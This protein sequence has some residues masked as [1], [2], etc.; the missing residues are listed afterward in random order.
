MNKTLY[1]KEI[2]EIKTDISFLNGKTVLFT[3]STGLIGS[4][5][6]DFIMQ[7]NIHNRIKSNVI[8]IGRNRKRIEKRFSD[9]TDNELFTIIQ[10][11]INNELDIDTDIDYI[12]HLASN[13]NPDLYSTKPI[14]TI[15]T[16]VFGTKNLLDLARKCNINKFIFAS[17][18]EIYGQ[19]ISD[20]FRFKEES[21]G[22]LELQTIRS[23]YP[24]SKRCAESLC[25]AYAKEYNVPTISARFSRIYGPSVNENDSRSSS[26]F[27]L[28]AANKQDIV[29]KSKGD[30]IFSFCYVA[31]AVSAILCLMKDGKTS[32]AYNIADEE[33]EKTIREFAEKT[34]ECSGITIRYDIE[35][36]S[37]FSNVKFALMDCSKI[38]SLGWAPMIHFEEGIKRT[39]NILKHE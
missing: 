8:V 35:N 3:G 30:K 25:L 33:S 6:V 27:L 24:E 12:V 10:H 22:Y 36:N 16:N 39:I 11:D 38:K 15:T 18:V 14:E 32:E 5:F 34:A 7:N 13:T 20:S 17:S 1:F 37:G 26:S 2:N 21:N 29:R 23:G 31:D 9:Y 28:S 4:Y 19:P